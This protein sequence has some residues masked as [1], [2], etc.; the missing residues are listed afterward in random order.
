MGRRSS[1]STTTCCYCDTVV[2]TDDQT[3]EQLLQQWID[4]YLKSPIE[5]RPAIIDVRPFTNF[6]TSHVIGSSHFSGLHS[7]DG[8]MLRLSELPPPQAR[9][10]VALVADS[11]PH[12]REAVAQLC[13]RHFHDVLPVSLHMLNDHLPM[14]TGSV[15]KPLWHP[16]PIVTQA[17]PLI[18]PYIPDRSALDIGC[19]AGRDTSFLA[20]HGFRVVAVD[21]DFKSVENCKRLASRY[22]SNSQ[23]HGHVHGVVRTL[24]A[25]TADD[26]RFLACNAA[27]LLLVV[28]FLRRPILDHLWKAVKPG[29]FVVYEHFLQGC[30]RFGGPVKQSQML[31]RGELCHVFSAA[32]G[33]SIINDE[34]CTLHDGRPIV[35]FIA[36]RNAQVQVAEAEE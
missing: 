13:A 23:T 6:V 14:E 2:T 22:A 36:Q 31:R 33:F 19:G 8:L 30:E 28:R 27:A 3:R 10:H 24:G 7:S 18:L 32:R 25:H 34:E 26:A 21:R 9:N 15:T 16:A 12:A 35:R 29:G 5:N 20:A 17:L 1:E 11:L 4:F